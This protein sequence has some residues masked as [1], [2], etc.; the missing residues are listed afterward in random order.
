MLV[1]EEPPSTSRYSSASVGAF[2]QQVEAMVLR[3]SNH[4]SVVMWGSFNEEWGLDWKV[5]E[6][7][8]RQ[9]VVRETAAL[10]RSLDPVPPGNR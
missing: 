6:D 2:R 7:H 10:L 9:Q 4:P 3:D 5:A 1:W 8:E